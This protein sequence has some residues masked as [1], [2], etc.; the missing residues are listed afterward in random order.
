MQL[1]APGEGWLTHR[2]RRDTPQTPQRSDNV[3]LEGRNEAPE[4]NRQFWPTEVRAK[5][6]SRRLETEL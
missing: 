4:F 6:H 3:G 5:D 2:K 1:P